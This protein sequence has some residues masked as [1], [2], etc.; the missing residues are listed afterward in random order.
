[1]NRRNFLRGLAAAPV[2]LK[3]AP[4]WNVLPLGSPAVAVIAEWNDYANFSS[5]ATAAAMDE[6]VRHAAEELGHRA[7]ES[8]IEYHRFIF[9]Q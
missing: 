3:L 8:I 6:A 4:I 2:G 1:V 9:D 7:G 5:M